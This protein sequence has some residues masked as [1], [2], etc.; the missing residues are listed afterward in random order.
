MAVSIIVEDGTPLEN[1]NSYCTLAAGDTYHEERLH[2]TDWTGATDDDKN[3]GLVQATRMLDELIAWNGSKVDEDQAL[4]WPRHNVYGPDG[5]T[6]DYESIPKFL[7][8]ATAEFARLLIASDRGADDDTAGFKRIKVDV[9]ELEMDKL[10]RSDTLPD[11][12]W[13]MCQFYG[14][15]SEGK[16]TIP[17]VRT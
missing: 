4:R 8:E 17:L 11:S 9:I 1:S 13:R 6:V 2:V 7:R 3:R 16:S 10:D 5:Y 12:V 15:K 14:T